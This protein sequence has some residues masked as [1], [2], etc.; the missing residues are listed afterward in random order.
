MTGSKARVVILWSHPRS[1]STMFEMAFLQREEF[2]T[3]HEPFGEPFYYGP[4]RMSNRFTPEGRPEDFK[5]Y[6]D[7]TFDK[8]WKDV[9]QVNGDGKFR[10]FVKDMA[11]YI[12]PPETSAKTTPALP[13]FEKDGNPTVIPTEQLLHP[14]IH[15]AFLVRT[16]KKAVP[17][18]YKLCVPPKSEVTGFEFFET[19]EVGIRE[20]KMLYDWL[21]SQGQKPIIIDAADLLANPVPTMKTFCEDCQVDFTEDMCSW[22]GGQAQEQFKKWNGF[23]DDAEQSHGIARPG[24]CSDEEARKAKEAKKA[25]EAAEMPELAQSAIRKNMA[26][27]E[28][29]TAKA[30]R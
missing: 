29:L 3:L 7:L 6:G 21:V 22:E 14:D 16:P 1:C 30:T 8:M 10:T 17:S 28:Y 20:S 15:H 4:E 25:K 19:E 26:D 12:V 2:R 18:Y 5:K 24:D 9:T 11:Q 13:S 23:H 27:Y